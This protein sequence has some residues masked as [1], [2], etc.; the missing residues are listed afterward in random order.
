[1][2]LCLCKVIYTLYNAREASAC[3]QYVGYLLCHVD[4]RPDSV[5]GFARAIGARVRAC[6]CLCVCE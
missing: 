3:F 2:Y 6:E 1:M 5:A 4:S